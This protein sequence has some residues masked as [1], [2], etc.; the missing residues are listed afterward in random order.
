MPP[1]SKNPKNPTKRAFFQIKETNS[2][3][4]GFVN[5]YRNDIPR[6]SKKLLGFYEFSKAEKEIKI[7][8]ELLD[9]YKTIN[10]ALAE[11]CGLTIRQSITGRQYV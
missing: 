3:Y 7:T 1:R 6:Q 11:A 10:A 9:K 4:V 2:R 5:Y 8:K